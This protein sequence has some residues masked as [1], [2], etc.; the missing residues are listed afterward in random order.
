MTFVRSLADS[1]HT[2]GDFTDR[3]ESLRT[4]QI[5]ILGHYAVTYWVDDPVK[6]V[7]IVSVEVADR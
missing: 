4:R 2:P 5:K 3:D 1:P 6:A 7:M